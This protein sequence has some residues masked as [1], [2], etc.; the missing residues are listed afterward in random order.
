MNQHQVQW[1][2]QVLILTDMKLMYLLPTQVLGLSIV[3]GD[4]S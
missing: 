2:E 4:L 1:K 3:P